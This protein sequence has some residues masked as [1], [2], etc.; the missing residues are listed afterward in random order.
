MLSALPL[1]VGA[2]FAPLF[3]PHNLGVPIST[4]F[5]AIIAGLFYVALGV[6]DLTLIHREKLLEVVAYVLLYIALLLFFMQ[7]LSGIFFFIWLYA[8]IC[9]WLSFLLIAD[10][11]RA[12][13]L[14]ATLMGELIWIVSWLP[15]GFLNSASICFALTLFAGDAVRENRISAKN[16]V[17]LGA[18]ITLIFVTSYWRI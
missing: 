4:L 15:I 1:F 16:T 3:F 7:A 12:A 17:V 8:V 10:D 14:F 18:L 13:L 11:Y 5:S 6:K 9:A 2:V